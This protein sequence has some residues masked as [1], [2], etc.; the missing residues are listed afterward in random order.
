M[1]LAPDHAPGRLHLAEALTR[2]GETQEALA[3]LQAVVLR[4]PDLAA[5][6]LALGT[7]L[8]SAGDAE[9]A[10]EEFRRAIH[11]APRDPAARHNLGLALADLDR[12]EEEAHDFA[13]RLKVAVAGPWTL[14][15]NLGVLL[16]TSCGLA[17]W[18]RADVAP[19]LSALRRSAYLFEESIDR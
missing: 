1:A 18:S 12:L 16:G 19:Q 4:E 2:I 6:R 7:A 15:A 10:V 14:A 11:L 17:G 3:L 9:A 13:G 8:R 5:A